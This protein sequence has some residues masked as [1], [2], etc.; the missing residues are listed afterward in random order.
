MANEFMRNAGDM[1]MTAVDQ[2]PIGTVIPGGRGYRAV[3]AMGHAINPAWGQ[4]YEQSQQDTDRI[5]AHEANFQKLHPYLAGAAKAGGNLANLAAA[6]GVFG[7]LGKGAQVAQQTGF[8]ASNMMQG[9]AAAGQAARAAA[10]AASYAPTVSNAVNAVRGVLP[11]GTTVGKALK[12]GADYAPAAALAGAPALAAFMGSGGGNK[13]QPAA[14]AAGPSMRELRPNDSA[15]Y[16]A[17]RRNLMAVANARTGVAPQQTPAGQPREIP[18]QRD[19]MGDTL[20]GTVQ[21]H[22]DALNTRLSPYDNPQ[23]PVGLRAKMIGM[24]Q[25]PHYASASD[26]AGNRLI[27]AAERD[28]AATMAMPGVT[29]DQIAQARTRYLQQLGLVNAKSGGPMAQAQSLLGLTSQ[30]GDD[31]FPQ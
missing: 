15:E 10:P 3:S 19:Q 22:R 31:G 18:S 28:L 4:S 6:G 20:M 30:Y 24:T 29:D 25:K 26:V 8:N 23:W 5:A 17:Y 27:A 21:N 7:A 9:M 2:T 11:A 16:E 13:P 12:T 14:P 1:L